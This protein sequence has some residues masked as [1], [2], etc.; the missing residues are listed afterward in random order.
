MTLSEK[1][2]L[3]LEAAERHHL[4]DGTFDELSAM[5]ARSYEKLP[6][7]FT[8]QVPIDN[9]KCGSTLGLAMHKDI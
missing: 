4:S 6:K 3:W 9:L 2:K 7:W 1:C 8:K 5:L